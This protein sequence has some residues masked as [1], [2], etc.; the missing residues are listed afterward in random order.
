MIKRNLKDIE[1]T[2]SDAEISRAA[3]AT[4]GW[5]GSDM[6]NLCRDCAMA[7]VRERVRE[8][9]L[10]ERRFLRDRGMRTGRHDQDNILSELDLEEKFASLRPV[11]FNDF[12]F[13]VRAWTSRV[14]DQGDSI[15][16]ALGQAPGVN[17]VHYDSSSDEEES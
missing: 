5:S 15:A 2:L 12:H 1:H 3:N 11:N 6:E 17:G 13:A 16:A 8:V 4:E 9:V 7:P 10:A 14:N